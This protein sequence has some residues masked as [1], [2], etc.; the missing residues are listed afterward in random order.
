MRVEKIELTGF[1]SFA[2]KTVFELHRGITC[3]VGPNGCGKS[4]VVDSF[5]WVL[6]EQS[7]KSLRG[8]KMMEVVFDGSQAK[9]PRGMAEVCMHV[10]GLNGEKPDAVVSRRLYRSGES[11]YSINR[12]SCRLKDVKDLFLDTGLEL[13]SYSIF[14]QDN[15]SR[16]INSKPEERRFLI[17]EVAGV[18]KYKVRRAEAEN[19]LVSSRQ[20][21]QRLND[22]IGEVKRQINSLD[23]QAKKA[24][25]Y[26]KLLEELRI[27]E[28]KQARKLFLDLSRE[29][30]G[31][32]ESVLALKERNAA[33][34]AGLSELENDYS[35]RRLVMAEREKA[36]S[37]LQ[38][39]L[40][41]LERE[42]AGRERELAVLDTEKEGL[43]ENLIRLEYDQKE[44]ETK[45]ADSDRKTAEIETEK[46][47]L[48]GTIARLEDSL[49]EKGSGL[50]GIKGEMEE[51]ESRLEEARKNLFRSTGELGTLT[52][53]VSK[54]EL[55]L[56]G[57]KRKGES[58]SA[59]MKNEENELLEKEERLRSLQA[60]AI[61]KRN[62]SLFIKDEKEALSAELVSIKA[63]AD[64][65]RTKINEAREALA[66]LGSRA[67][68][69]RELLLDP[70]TREVLLSG[71]G[72]IDGTSLSDVIETAPEY[73]KAVEAALKELA[74]AFIVDD[75]EA[76]LKSLE[77]IKNKPIGRTAFIPGDI[78]CEVSEKPLPAG[79]IG[80]ASDLV[81]AGAQYDR[82]VRALLSDVIIVKDLNG[83][84]SANGFTLV[85]LSGEVRDRK[86]AY[87]GGQNRGLLEK[88]REL[89]GL[90][91]EIKAVRAQLE[92]S[93]KE[94]ER[95]TAQ[96]AEKE[97]G[98]KNAELRMH[99]LEKE[100]S[101][102]GQSV[103]NTS[104][105]IERIRKK[106]AYLRL[107]EEE[108]KR[109]FVRVEAA[110]KEKMD[111]KSAALLKK[112]HVEERINQVQ[113]ELAA[114]KEVFERER[115]GLVE[116]R[117]E[118]GSLKQALE[119]LNR[120][121]VSVR[122]AKEEAIRKLARAEED[123]KK[124]VLS[125]KEKE[126]RAE[127][128]TSLLREVVKKA[129]AVKENTAGKRRELAE[130]S[131]ALAGTEDRIKSLR[132]QID[133]LGRGIAEGEIRLTECSVRL[134]N[135]AEN[136]QTTYSVE[137]ANYEAEGPLEGEPERI[138]EL[139]GK[140][141]DLGPVSLGTI[142]EYEELKTR[143]EFLLTQKE[144]LEKSVAEL[145]EAI[146]KINYT[147]RKMLRDAYDGLNQKFGEI[148]V[149]FFGGGRAE[150][151]LT[152]ESN[153]LETGI[154]IV[155]QPPGKK[156]QNIHLLSGGEKSLT[157][158]SLLFSSF[159]IKPTP[160]CVL[161][162]ADAALDEYNT[163]KFAQMLRSLAGAT[164]FIVITHNRITMEA[165]DYIYG[166]TMQEPGVSK[167]I[168]M[169]FTPDEAAA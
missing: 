165:A 115:S 159:L 156:L 152:D 157:A 88:K 126:I 70:A 135:L 62:E 146:K 144:D 67:D 53:E 138:A 81:K 61:E 166:I 56:Q 101:L 48:S 12:N 77:A 47:S 112:S 83:S 8:D 130:L 133:T 121:A 44:L 141:A 96:I 100:S 163:Q 85:S 168:S 29:A 154:E 105:E 167:A 65:A 79:A 16:I 10:S 38:E 84:A 7:A 153:I 76:A 164:Q 23:R 95:Q 136:V 14:E 64:S 142:E 25:R 50:S 43:K 137:I 19:R 15:I 91:K 103:K 114:K 32:E 125:I 71:A 60:A 143:H 82:L 68:S 108:L 86:G 55:T 52:G 6:G 128:T 17:E 134:Q 26:K 120:E 117:M 123:A 13:K 149:E 31:A 3:I 87:T 2:E 24:E 40:Q 113:A 80:R 150:L 131:E 162:E 169:R 90:E 73:E 59:E 111:E 11:E 99:E 106:S 97:Q 39:E 104:D 9:K 92:A 102:I 132:G 118:L 93:E 54:G 69:I 148:F 34:R 57:L 155:A 49:S 72:R 75:E 42:I 46:G 139:K 74:S 129:E 107:E 78:A 94:L 66:S 151:R 28:L 22:I 63:K 119:N 124:G 45:I 145:E 4:N 27:L 127:E 89:R 58:L 122:Q 160:L 33:E 36:V 21:L 116:A 35:Q 41:A 37:V 147:T 140:L 20:N 5:K 1:K 110:L 109:E 30:S 158:L 51:L 161:D 18:V 98:M